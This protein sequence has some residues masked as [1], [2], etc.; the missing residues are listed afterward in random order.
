MF[1]Q[2]PNDMWYIVAYNRGIGAKM[3]QYGSEAGVDVPQKFIHWWNAAWRN[4]EYVQ[5]IWTKEGVEG[6]HRPM[7]YSDAKEQ[8][9]IA[10]NT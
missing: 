10:L 7:L 8:F 3:S 6:A 9:R 4:V 2:N 5:I 1:T